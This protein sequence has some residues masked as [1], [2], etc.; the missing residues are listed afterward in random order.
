MT[1]GFTYKEAGVDIEKAS[2]FVEAIKGLAQRTLKPWVIGGI[3][4]FSAAVR[5]PEGYEA[6]LLLA[7]CDGVGTKLKVAQALR[8]YN[9]VGIDLVAMCVNDL[10]PMG[11]RPLFFLDYLAAGSLDPERDTELLAGVVKGCEEADCSLV[12]GETAEMPGLYREGDFDLVGFAVGVV[13]ASRLVDGRTIEEG[14]VVVGLASSGL[15]SNGFSLVRRV[16]EA[17]GIPLDAHVEGVGALGEELLRPTRIY[18]RTV[19][20]LL[21]RHHLKGM[22]HITGGGLPENLPRV[23]PK[24]LGIRI[25]VTWEIPPIFRFIQSLGVPWEEM[26]RVFNMGIGFALIVDRDEVEAVV[27]DAVA[28]GEEAFVIGRVVRG[29]GVIIGG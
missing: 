13:E 14:D 2:K 29:E 23:L 18:A 9:T 10:L 8:R 12:G 21:A 6:P 20:G 25:R 28:L 22:A 27:E 1:G 5:I 24:G 4:G 19:Q 15:H 17:K 3:G 11:G 16:L 7:T 26:W